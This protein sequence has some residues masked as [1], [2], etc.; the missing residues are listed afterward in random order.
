MGGGGDCR[1]RQDLEEELKEGGLIY[2]AVLPPRSGAKLGAQHHVKFQELAS[3]E[4]FPAPCLHS[5]RINPQ[6][7]GGWRHAAS[8]DA[9]S[10]CPL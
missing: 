10:N 7:C 4:R 9:H 8:T 1:Q 5:R 6:T 2:M 3:S